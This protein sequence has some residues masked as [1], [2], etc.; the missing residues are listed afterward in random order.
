MAKHWDIFM[1]SV[2][3]AEQSCVNSEPWETQILLWKV[4]AIVP[5]L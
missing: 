4:C 1:F 3:Q 5:V 2:F